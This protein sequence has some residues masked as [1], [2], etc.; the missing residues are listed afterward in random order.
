[1]V[2]QVP[3]HAARDR[4]RVARD[5]LPEIVELGLEPA[6]I[7]VPGEAAGAREHLVGDVVVELEGEAGAAG[8]RED[9]P[10]DD[11]GEE[12]GGEESARAPPLLLRRAAARDREQPRR[13]QV[14]RVVAR[15][16]RERGEESRDRRRARAA[17]R[18]QREQGARLERVRE[19]VVGGR[20]AVAEEVRVGGDEQ[21]PEECQARVGAAREQCEPGEQARRGRGDRD[22]LG[23]EEEIPRR[24]PHQRERH[25]VDRPH[26]TVARRHE[27]AALD[28][29]RPLGVVA[30][31]IGL[32]EVVADPVRNERDVEERHGA[33]QKEHGPPPL[34]R[35]RRVHGAGDRQEDRESQRDPH[36]DP[37]AGPPRTSAISGPPRNTQ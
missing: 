29:A 33:D 35:R 22:Q 24:E 3:Q 10:R 25:F 27:P 18:E 9:H 5:H 1:M 7:F 32:G 8:E 26:H 14:D 12:A 34:V 37:H 16:E 21:R 4:P 15:E 31:E 13:E 2:E 17:A 20:L 28:Q 19:R 6:L 23:G 11:R 36:A 30:V